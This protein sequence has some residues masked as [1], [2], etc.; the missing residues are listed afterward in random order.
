MIVG[1][2]HSWKSE[3]R[4]EFEVREAFNLM[5][6]QNEVRKYLLEI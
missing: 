6:S 1:S 5:I 4:E 2:I 3:P